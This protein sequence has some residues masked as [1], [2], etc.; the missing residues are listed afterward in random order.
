MPNRPPMIV[1]FRQNC[2]RCAAFRRD[3]PDWATY[4]WVVRPIC[5]ECA[6]LTQVAELRSTNEAELISNA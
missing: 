3:H 4:I 2:G 1:L 6:H 5:E